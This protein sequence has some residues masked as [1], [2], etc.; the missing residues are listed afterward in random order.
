M[1]YPGVG[2]GL[3]RELHNNTQ[4]TIVIRVSAAAMGGGVSTVKATSVRPR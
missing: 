2:V 1:Q 3:L 4:N